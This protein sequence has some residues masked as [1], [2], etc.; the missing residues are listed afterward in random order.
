MNQTFKL[1]MVNRKPYLTIDED[2]KVGDNAI[3][4]VGDMY[5]SL[6]EC[7]ND[8]QINLIQ[9]PNTKLTKRYKVVMNPEQ[10]N[11]EETVIQTLSMN[12]LPVMVEYDNGEIKFIE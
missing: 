12:D 3:V 6:V 11:L 2:V 7:K 10:I 1:F 4:T 5:P 9:N 8:D